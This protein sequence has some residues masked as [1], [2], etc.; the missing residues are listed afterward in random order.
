M[1]SFHGTVSGAIPPTFSGFSTVGGS[2]TSIFTSMSRSM[3]R[4]RSRST[5]TLCS[6]YQSSNCLVTSAVTV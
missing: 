4:S 1:M 5:S 2:S 3:S 6:R